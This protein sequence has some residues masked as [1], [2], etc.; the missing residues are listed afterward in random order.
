L[1]RR[2]TPPENYNLSEDAVGLT[3]KFNHSWLQAYAPWLAYSKTLKVTFCLYCVLFPP[4]KVQGVLGSFIIKPFI[5]YK[6]IHESCRNHISN[7]WHQRVTEAAKSFMKLTYKYYDGIRAPK[8]TR[9]KSKNCFVNN[10]K[11]TILRNP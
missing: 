9:T 1:K 6:D 8:N 7:N 5:R 3:R 11:C 4:K 10:F 2:W